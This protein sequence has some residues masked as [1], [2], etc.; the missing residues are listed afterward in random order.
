[1]KESRTLLTRL[2]LCR[3]HFTLCAAFLM[4]AILASTAQAG[5]PNDIHLHFLY[6]G[7]TTEL[8]NAQQNAFKKLSA[9]YGFA[10]TE[11]VLAPAET[12]GIAGM[13]LGVSFS[14]ADIPENQEH[15]V[16]SV[17]DERPDN[18]LVMTR[19]RFRKGLPLSLEIEG[20]TGFISGS[21]AMTAGVGFKWALNEGFYYFPAISIRGSVNRLFSSRDL[22]LMSVT[23]DV[24]VSKQFPIVGMFT[25]TPYIGYSFVYVRADSSVL[26]PTPK[27]FDDNESLETGNFVFRSMNHFGNRL[28]FGLRIVWFIL[29][30]NLEGSFISPN[31]S[32]M[33]GS[34]VD[35][36]SA[37]V[38]AFSTKLSLFF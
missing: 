13:D 36:D 30:L 34:S 11:P 32:T 18:S 27:S 19:I 17:E 25:L 38:G 5:N 3:V 2:L 9:E 35:L 26:D 14:V 12:L 10:M 37:T 31:F 24:W 15:W 8:R 28:F 4:F 20:S 16:R 1:M 21:T 6:K 33:N 22:H 7:K 23:G 29:A